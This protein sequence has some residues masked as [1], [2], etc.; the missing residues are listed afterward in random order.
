MLGQRHLQSL[1]DN[2]GMTVLVA[3]A[4]WVI[5]T[6]AACIADLMTKVEERQLFR[7]DGRG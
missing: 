2:V 5:R 1:V 3:R 4:F 6:V 7:S